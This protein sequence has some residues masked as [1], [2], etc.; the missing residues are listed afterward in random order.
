MGSDAGM[1]QA[2]TTR[3]VA[4]DSLVPFFPAILLRRKSSHVQ[5][6]F[7]RNPKNAEEAISRPASLNRHSE[8]DFPLQTTSCAVL[9]LLLARLVIRHC[10]FQ[11]LQ[12][13]V[14][15]TQLRHQYSLSLW[16]APVV[17]VKFAV[18][19]QTVNLMQGEMVGI[20][21]AGSV[22]SAVLQDFV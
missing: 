4:Y 3:C 19:P 1:R 15:L 8:H 9:E 10:L 21:I 11:Y 6:T 12:Q 20:Q 14:R 2:T 5:D 17:R 22:G 13:L 18:F 7:A 16:Y